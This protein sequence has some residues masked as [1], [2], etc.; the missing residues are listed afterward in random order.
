[1]NN[2]FLC[3]YSICILDQW[4]CASKHS[5]MRSHFDRVWECILYTPTP[6]Q[7]HDRFL[8]HA[9]AVAYA[10]VG[11]VSVIAYWPTIRDL[12]YHK[13]R[14]A[15]VTSYVLWT[16]TT[17]IAFLYSLFILSDLLLRIVSGLNFSF[18]AIVL[19]LSLNLKNKR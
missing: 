7:Y 17:G 2:F 11:I 13:K 9:L 10:G 12:Y 5:K 16:A 19:A 14:S 18:C 8:L 6:Y 1:M 3:L 15:N 4:V